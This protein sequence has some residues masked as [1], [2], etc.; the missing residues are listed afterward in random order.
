VTMAKRALVGVVLGAAIAVAVI[1][2]SDS[3]TSPPATGDPV[4]APRV[5]NLLGVVSE[6]GGPRPAG[7]ST[8][9]GKAAPPATAG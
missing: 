8:S 3:G 6:P 4:A 2:F 7:A 5:R 9:A 1:A